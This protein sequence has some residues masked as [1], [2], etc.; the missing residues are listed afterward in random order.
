M[1]AA[2]LAMFPDAPARLRRP[3]EPIVRSARVEGPFRF[4]LI[5]AWGSGPR[6]AIAG[7]NPSYADGKR[8][9]P[10]MWRGMSFA[11][12]LGF[13]S[14]VM[15]NIYPLIT[16]SLAEL[17]RWRESWSHGGSLRRSEGAEAWS[18]NCHAVANALAGCRAYLAA[19]GN[20]IDP[21]DFFIWRTT[22]EE[23]MRR[24]APIHW[25]CLGTN[26]D[27]SPKHLIA[28]GRHRIP[29]DAQLVPWKGPSSKTAT[30]PEQTDARPAR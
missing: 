13:G 18:I 15:V 16:P 21:R 1:T 28:R 10:T 27:G 24:A 2:Q 19:W 3:P 8:D 12:R 9:D 5:R 20:G 6:L 7:C 23:L 30:P 22:V 14:L 25:S 29:D 26:A 17:R 11:Y 4:E